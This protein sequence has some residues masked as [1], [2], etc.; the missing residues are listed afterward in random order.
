M[1]PKSILL[2]FI[3]AMCSK[4]VLPPEL[5]LVMGISLCYTE[6]MENQKK[7][8]MA[9]RQLTKIT[10]LLKLGTGVRVELDFIDAL[11]EEEGILIGN[12]CKGFVKAMSENR[13]VDTYPRRVFRV[14]A[15]A[16]HQYVYMRDGVTKY[17]A[18]VEP[19]DELTVFSPD[20]FR[21]AS[22]G[23]VKKEKRPLWRIELENGIS[24]TVQEADSVYLEGSGS[25]SAFTG[26]SEGDSLASYPAEPCGR[27]K[28]EAVAEYI[29]EL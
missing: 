27:H 15:G 11:S 10:R 20:G 23:R 17:L 26:L 18:E 22:V 21:T 6:T 28:G 16:L 5:T 9:E 4:C 25:S 1:I 7:E 8:W 24:A 2:Y 3:T 19:G 14:N 29:E 13:E 12:T